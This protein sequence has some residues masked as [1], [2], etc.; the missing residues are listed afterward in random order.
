MTISILTDFETIKIYDCRIP[1]NDDD[2]AQTALFAQFHC[3]E[4]VERWSEIQALISR[5]AVI[6]GS[7]DALADVNAL[8]VGFIPVDKAFL[9]Q[10]EKWRMWLAADI[11]ATNT[12]DLPSLNYAIQVIIDRIIFLR[13]A[14]DRGI[15]KHGRLLQLC[16]SIDIYPRLLEIFRKA[17]ARYNSGLFHFENTLGQHDQPD[18]IT[19]SLEI[20]NDTLS[21]MLR[22]L[23]RP[24]SAYEFSVMP[25]E[26]LGQ[27][28]EQ[29]LGKIIRQTSNGA[30]VENKPEVKKAGGV[31]YT[32]SDI[33][34]FI[35]TLSLSP[36]LN[37]APL[38]V[39]RKIGKKIVRTALRVVDPAC[40]SGSFLIEVYQYLLDWHLEWYL[41][42]DPEKISRGRNPKIIAHANSWRLSIAEK[43][44]IL[45]SHIYGV[46]IDSQAVEVTKLSL[47][48]KMIEGESTDRIAAQM[49]LFE[50]RV[51]PDISSN[52]RCGNSLVGMDIFAKF[53]A[54]F[55][56]DDEFT[57]NNPFE[58]SDE[59]PFSELEGSFDVVVGNPPYIDSEW[60]TK[61]WPDERKYCSDRYSYASG[62]WDI[63]C[64]FIGKAIDL[65]CPEGIAT[66]IVPNKLMTASYAAAVRRYL[67]D[68]G[69][70]QYI[71]DYSSVSV[72]PVA[73]YPI[74]FSYK[75]GVEGP[76]KYEKVSSRTGTSTVV[77]ETLSVKLLSSD[78]EWRFE[79]ETFSG[80]GY[81]PL[82]RV[83]SI[84]DAATVAEAYLLKDLLTDVAQPAL[85]DLKVVNS[86]T[87]DPYEINWGQKRLR[88]LGRSLT[89]PVL[90][91]SSLSDYSE[92]RVRQSKSPKV[93][94]ANMTKKLEAVF[95]EEGELLAGKSVNVI[96]P[97]CNPWLILAILNSKF[98]SLYYE[99]KFHGRKLSGGYLQIAPSALGQ[100]PIP[101]EIESTTISMFE[102]EC[103]QLQKLIV[104]LRLQT[105]QE[106]TVN[107]RRITHVKAKIEG[108]VEALY[109]PLA[110]VSD[111]EAA[112]S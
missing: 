6:D 49:D 94:V 9:A 88:Y 105:G 86:G 106:R 12:I 25:A 35:V 78:A 52:I 47:L 48:L 4:F 87:I 2:S 10:I 51:L 16:E 57:R 109:A 72:F 36:Y 80:A 14:E 108:M 44:R 76:T 111:L 34:R 41:S 31:Y 42:N 7:L 93:L 18:K 28:Y 100:L 56:S 58:W 53:P 60:M 33:V 32:P 91:H 90:E 69:Q 8:S 107:E 84:N 54:S 62:N 85:G 20:S 63:F 1:P 104:N 95:D 102:K 59:F 15:E 17:D 27:V 39:Q 101:V 43:K 83:A 29:F 68:R 112:L 23:Y 11:S 40:G 38:L 70:L 5:Q 77:G 26:I 89:C 96:F 74:V 65:L 73:V 21:K 71:R 99:Q 22:S 3:D 98:M 67:L 46:D 50:T 37:S 19:P 24:E 13:I 79:G 45:L 30:I 64:A 92:R 66:M 81:V 75:S 55:L 97:R 61:H 82:E 103:R 110:D